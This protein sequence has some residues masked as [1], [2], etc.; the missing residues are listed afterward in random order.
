MP[1]KDYIKTITIGVLMIGVIFF[2]QNKMHHAAMSDKLVQ[3]INEKYGRSP[4]PVEYCNDLSY[5]INN[6]GS[7][8]ESMRKYTATDCNSILRNR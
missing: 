4:T 3:E 2:I 1:K 7:A 8:E 5:R 6:F